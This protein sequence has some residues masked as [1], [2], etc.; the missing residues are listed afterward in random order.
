[1]MH[2]KLDINWFLCKLHE[3]IA[4]EQKALMND[5]GAKLYDN[6]HQP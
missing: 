5:D 3:F 2:R 6:L 1:M 4:L